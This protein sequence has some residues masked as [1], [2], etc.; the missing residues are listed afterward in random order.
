MNCDTCIVDRPADKWMSVLP[1]DDAR[2]AVDISLE[3]AAALITPQ[4]L[5]SCEPWALAERALVLAYA[6]RVAPSPQSADMFHRLLSD[7][8]QLSATVAMS[9]WLYTGSLFVG[10][11]HAH[12]QTDID[13]SSFHQAIDEGFI[14]LLSDATWAPPFD[15]LGGLAG[16]GLYWLERGP[17]SSARRGL[18]ALVA[19]LEVRADRTSAGTRWSTPWVFQFEPIPLPDPNDCY[20]IGMAHG[21][22]S[23]IALL[24]RIYRAGVAQSQVASLLEETVTWLLQQRRAGT[25]SQFP[26]VVGTHVEQKSY[27]GWCWGDIGVIP[28]ITIAARVLQRPEWEATA[29][30]LARQAAT[31]LHPVYDDC[32]CHGGVGNGHLFNRMYQLWKLTELRD[33]ALRWYRIG[34]GFR[35]PGQGTAGFYRTQYSGKGTEPVD[36][37]DTQFLFGASGVALGLLAAGS[38]VTPGWDRLMLMSDPILD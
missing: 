2:A 16:L 21:V 24:A 14:E 9:P 36:L 28:A 37:N 1:D 4:S 5:E 32:L 29:I 15:V 12:L 20:A 26:A 3:I 8:L 33:A 27:F 19:H 6:H 25:V 22:S 35:K 30:E 10:W 11:T 7:A 23:V 17:D 18:E 13:A 38:N 31:Q 34:L